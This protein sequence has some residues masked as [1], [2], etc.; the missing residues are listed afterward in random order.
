MDADVRWKAHRINTRKLP[1]D[2]MD[3]RLL[4]DNGLVR[5]EPLNFG[6]AGGDIRSIIRMD[7]REKTIRTRADIT[8][9]GLNLRQLLPTVELAS[10]AVGKVGGKLAVHGSGNSTR[11]LGRPTANRPSHG[12]GRSATS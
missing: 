9:R 5:L 1:I 11:M 12:R 2:D 3:A 7:A 10:D 8:A 6:V 4:M